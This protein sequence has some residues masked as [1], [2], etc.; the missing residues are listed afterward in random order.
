MS[1]S[2]SED[3]ES[4]CEK[5]R[6]IIMIIFMCFILILSSLI[7]FVG[8]LFTF[9]LLWTEDLK[10]YLFVGAKADDGMK[11]DDVEA[12]TNQKVEELKKQNDDIKKQNEDV[13]K[14]NEDIKKQNEEFKK[15]VVELKTL[16]MDTLTRLDA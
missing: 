13:K 14:Q 5:V 12:E 8:G 2:F 11:E 6:L 3:D 4:A 10:E 7:S 16:L 15:E 1:F 9:G